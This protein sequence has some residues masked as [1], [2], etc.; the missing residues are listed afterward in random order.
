MGLFFMT[1]GME[2][3]VSLMISSWRSLCVQL[4]FLLVGKVAV[5]AAIG[6]AFGISRLTALRSGL[7]LAPGGEFAFVTFGEAAAQG[8]LP[9][10]L[11]TQLYLVVALS[12]AVL[13]YLAIGGAK[14]GKIMEKGDMKVGKRRAVGA[15]LLMLFLSGHDAQRSRDSQSPRPHHHCW[16]WPCWTTHCAASQ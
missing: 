10:A 5:M 2:I 4:M 15:S 6:P 16:I 1:V 9:T 7:M 13:P 11:V 14:L 3:S 12:M 8:I